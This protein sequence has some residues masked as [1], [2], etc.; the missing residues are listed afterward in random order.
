[1]NVD[2]IH[3]AF[4]LTFTFIWLIVGQIIVDGR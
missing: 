3:T 4:G 1:M 2:A